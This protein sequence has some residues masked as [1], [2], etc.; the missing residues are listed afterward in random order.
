MS[1]HFAIPLQPTTYLFFLFPWLSS[2]G[3]TSKKYWNP[4]FARPIF[5][6]VCVGR[7]CSSGP[8]QTPKLGNRIEW[9][10][11]RTSL[12]SLQMG[13]GSKWKFLFVYIVCL[14]INNINREFAISRLFFH[15]YFFLSTYNSIHSVRHWFLVTKLLCFMQWY[16]T[17]PIPVIHAT[18]SCQNHFYCFV[19]YHTPTTHVACTQ[20]TSQLLVVVARSS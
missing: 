16:H 18:T 15:T 20:K 1:S 11:S 17:I 8:Y 9:S 6:L 4:N 7:T 13:N 19:Q 14:H 10:G 5:S 2:N 3:W 12:Y